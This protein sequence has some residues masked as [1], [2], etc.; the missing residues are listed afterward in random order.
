MDAFFTCIYIDL[1]H[2]KTPTSST[3]ALILVHSKFSS[4]FSQLN[5]IIFHIEIAY[6]IIQSLI[7]VVDQ[8]VF[9]NT[10]VD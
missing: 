2:L 6:N 8:I 3:R 4:Q 1:F 10:V 9:L 5:S 7:C